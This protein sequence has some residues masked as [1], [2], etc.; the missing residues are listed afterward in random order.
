[1]LRRID[2]RAV[3]YQLAFSPDGSRLAA[4]FG[5]GR[6][7]LC[8]TAGGAA[9]LTLEGHAGKV[10]CVAF[11][12]DGRQLA[13]GGGDRTLRLW[14]LGNGKQQGERRGHFDDIFTVA[15]SPDGRWIASGG[16]DRTVRV[17]RTEGGSPT[18]LPN[19]AG[20]VWQLAFGAGGDTLAVLSQ[21]REEA[22]VW[23]APAWA[24]LRVLKGHT[25]FIYTVACSPDGR[26]IA[27][28][29]WDHVIRL[30]D[31]AGGEPLGVLRARGM[32][33]PF[34]LAFSPD[35]RRLVSRGDD[36]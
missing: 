5:D 29:G 18:V 26:L 3:I 13:S 12:P 20:G 36:D 28:A 34:A 9:A 19:H 31:A 8:D 17:W 32:K 24:D 33:I 2:G 15:Y 10:W 21:D 6:V 16:M 14:D 1:V 25:S 11:R 23:P 22:R 27:S 30:W 7:C 4:A 35:G